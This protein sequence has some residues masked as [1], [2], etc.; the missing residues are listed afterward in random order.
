MRVGDGRYEI[1]CTHD[2]DLCLDE[3]IRVCPEGFKVLGHDTN[4]LFNYTPGVYGGEMVIQCT[5][6]A[7]TQTAETD[8]ETAP[9][10]WKTHGA[11]GPARQ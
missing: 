6:E 2:S 4:K 3:A 9:D 7:E 10:Y 8:A 1:G 5:G 11:Y